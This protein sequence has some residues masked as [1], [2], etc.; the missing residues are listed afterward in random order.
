MSNGNAIQD[1]VYAFLGKTSIFFLWVYGSACMNWMYAALV[2]NIIIYT[3]AHIAFDPLG[4]N[5]I[6]EIDMDPIWILWSNMDPILCAKWII[7]RKA[8]CTL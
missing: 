5:V 3:M 2:K 4:C 1:Q 8:K 7:Y 6:S